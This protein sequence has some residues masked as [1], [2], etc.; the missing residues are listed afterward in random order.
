MDLSGVSIIKRRMRDFIVELYNVA[1][2]KIRT[3]G[4]NN[5]RVLLSTRWKYIGINDGLL[6]DLVILSVFNH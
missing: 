6:Q 2:A 1:I 5:I 4:G 3:I